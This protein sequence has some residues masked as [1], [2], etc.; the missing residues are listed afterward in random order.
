LV[1]NPSKRLSASDA[2]NHPYLKD[3]KQTELEITLDDCITIPLN[4]NK[5]L[6]LQDYRD[7]L[8]KGLITKKHNTLVNI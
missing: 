6:K 7:A 3:F 1:Y 8:Y 5:K 4:D 2:L